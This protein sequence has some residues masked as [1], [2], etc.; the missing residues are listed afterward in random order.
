MKKIIGII[1]ILVGGFLIYKGVAR[2]DS[3]AGE[4]DEAGSDI[5]NKV[6]G[7]SRIPEHYYYFIGG[8]ILAAAGIAATVGGRKAS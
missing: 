7:G 8:G 6:D 1:L 5:A 3:L 2:D 4:L